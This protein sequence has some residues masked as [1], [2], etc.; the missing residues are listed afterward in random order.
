MLRIKQ[1]A[2]SNQQLVEI[3]VPNSCFLVSG[4]TQGG[5]L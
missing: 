1:L 4:P 2:N 5:V 3:L